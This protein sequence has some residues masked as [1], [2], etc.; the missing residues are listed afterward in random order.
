MQSEAG[1][2]SYHVYTLNVDGANIRRINDRGDD[3]CSFYFPDGKR[4]VWTSTRDHP[5]LPKGNYSDP[6]NYPQG[7][8][9]YTSLW[10]ERC[11][12]P[13]RHTITKRKFPCGPT[14]SGYCSAGR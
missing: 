5:E 6:S 12:S 13:D 3:A 4:I 9:L 1:D 2:D 7:A 11:S 8:E 10:T 14:A